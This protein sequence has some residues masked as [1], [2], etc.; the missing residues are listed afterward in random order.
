MRRRE[1]PLRLGLPRVDREGA[2][3]RLDRRVEPPRRGLGLTQPEP[4]KTGLRVTRRERL[5]PPHGLCD[6]APLDQDED[7]LRLL[8]CRAV[9]EPGR[10]ERQEREG[11]R[12]RR[13]QGDPAKRPHPRGVEEEDERPA[14]R[15]RQRDVERQ[16]VPRRDEERRD[17]KDV[18][19]N[20]RDPDGGIAARKAPEPEE[21]EEDADSAERDEEARPDGEEPQGRGLAAVPGE[22]EVE[23]RLVARE[24]VPELSGEEPRGLA[25]VRPD[26]APRLPGE[27]RR[28]LAGRQRPPRLCLG[29]PSSR[30]PPVPRSTG[31]MPS[32]QR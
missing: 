26:P 15:R 1:D 21:H 9:L 19:R 10:P 2:A 28:H 6:V 22:A 18:D 25:R 31:V 3:E 8:L 17:E 13:R 32:S 11:Q 20:E 4:E 7:P 14:P 29:N 23:R 12:D 27:V 30:P 5:G 24:D 16:P